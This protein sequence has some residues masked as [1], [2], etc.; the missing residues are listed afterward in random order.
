MIIFIAL[1]C[2]VPCLLLLLFAPSPTP[3]APQDDDY[4]PDDDVYR[5]A[6][7]RLAERMKKG[8]S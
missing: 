8:E 5:A 4:D 7:V 6:A 1:L 3:D 2:G